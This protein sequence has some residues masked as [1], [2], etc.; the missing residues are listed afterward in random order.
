MNA[1]FWGDLE[2]IEHLLRGGSLSAGARS[3]GVNQTTVARRLAALERRFG[4][5]LF[6]RIG[7][8]LVAGPALDSVR[9]R[10]HGLAQDAAI[11]LAGLQQAGAE[12]HGLVRVTS[13][14]FILARLL[15]PA[16]GSFA[17]KNPA[18][19]LELIADDHAL[20]FARR[21]TDIAIRMGSDADD[22]STRIRKLGDLP[23]ALYR[24]LDAPAG[25]R[26]VV[27]YSESLAH[28]PEMRLLDH[29]RPAAQTA[30]TS[31]RL[32]VLIAA[33]PS[34]G[35]EI[36]LP[37]PVARHDPRFVRQTPDKARR[38]VHLL[39]QSDRAS[40]PA[41]ARAAGWIDQLLRTWLAEA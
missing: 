22:D 17:A 18:I 29:L 19:R 32:D 41:V 35:A 15:A 9:P 2:L 36:M 37:V 5:S 24:P 26:P 23:F 31:T 21:E 4:V 13:I 7:G 30:L 28:T 8:R 3:L 39:I 27:R 38:S 10:L 33:A 1:E 12:W 40:Q 11:T 6:D 25:P 16:C 14:G 20:S 34:L